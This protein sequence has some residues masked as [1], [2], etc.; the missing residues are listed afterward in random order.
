MRS[1]SR[2]SWPTWGAAAGAVDPA[3][4]RRYGSALGH[5]L[6]FCARHDIRK[7]YPHAAP[8]A[9]DFRL[10]FAAF[11]ADRRSPPNG[12]PHAAARPMRGQ[13]FVLDTVRAMPEWAADPGRGDLLPDG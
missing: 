6:A 3:T 13:A 2:G 12:H 4:V 7:C 8:L 10:A 11:L 1:W 9:R 5:Y